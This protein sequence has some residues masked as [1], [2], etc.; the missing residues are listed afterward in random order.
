[1]KKEELRSCLLKYIKTKGLLTIL[2]SMFFYSSSGLSQ[3]ALE[4]QSIEAETAYAPG[5]LEVMSNYLESKSWEEGQNIKANGKTF[6]V[7][8]GVGY[9]AADTKSKSYIQSRVN[10]YNKAVL[11]AKKNLVEFLEL[12]V[13]TD[14]ESEYKEPGESREQARIDA[15]IKAGKEAEEAKKS[16]AAKVSALKV[17]AENKDWLGRSEV[18]AEEIS[19]AETAEAVLRQGLEEEIRNMGLN[20]NEPI[21]GQVIK[22]IISQE[23]FRKATKTVGQARIAGLTPFRTF[24]VVTKGNKGQIGVIM[25][26][27][28]KTEQIAD[29]LYSGDMTRMP[30]GKSKMPLMDQISK[31]KAGLVS[32]FGVRVTRDEEGQYWLLSYG[33]A[34]PKTTSER[35]MGAAIA[36]AKLEA[37]S[38]L[39]LFLGSVTATS[40]LSENIET[41][42]ELADGSEVYENDES[43]E[44]VIKDS[45]AALKISGMSVKKRWQAEHPL[46]GQPIAGV[47]IGWSPTQLAQA[48]TMK[49]S[50][51]QVPKPTRNS[52]S[53]SETSAIGGDASGDYGAMGGAVSDEDDF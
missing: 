35:S 52:S 4:L 8:V 22:K 42:T 41:V 36:K 45:A 40:S 28:A 30:T 19:A 53:G 49:A 17:D 12:S 25:I 31:K 39:R 37:Q 5:V 16:A 11:N 23:K 20:P 32:E 27:S 34:A 33:Q 44:E 3:E 14:L 46:T 6:Y 51:K 24:E 21:D 50:M 1:M 43:F 13:Q 10:A 38:N 29:A 15:L 18:S 7:G 2:A 26:H 48:K 47:V 9:I